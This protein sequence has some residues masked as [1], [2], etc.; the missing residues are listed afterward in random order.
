MHMRLGRVARVAAVRD[1]LTRR[2]V[3]TDGNTNGAGLQVHES[4]EYAFVTHRDDQIVASDR[5]HSLP[6]PCR[7]AQRIWHQSQLRPPP[8]MITLAIVHG[9][10]D[11][12]SW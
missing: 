2:H 12:V 5:S 11:A 7:L 10:D 4:N 3:L 8:N 9:D 6:K 1:R